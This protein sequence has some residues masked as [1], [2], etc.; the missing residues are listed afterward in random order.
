[1]S[2]GADFQY[3]PFLATQIEH[4]EFYRQYYYENVKDGFYSST[5]QNLR[6]GLYVAGQFGKTKK[7]ELNLK[8]G[9]QNNGEYDKLVPN[10]YAIIGINKSF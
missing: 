5:A 7:L 6:L 3:N 10:A 9:Y 4:S 8:G 1:M 2:L